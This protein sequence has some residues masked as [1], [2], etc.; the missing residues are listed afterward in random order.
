MLFPRGGY[1]IL[2]NFFFVWLNAGNH[3]TTKPKNN[4]NATRIQR[5][6]VKMPFKNFGGQKRLKLDEMGGG[7]A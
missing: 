4:A 3:K 6:I 1:F 7:G 2:P 5:K